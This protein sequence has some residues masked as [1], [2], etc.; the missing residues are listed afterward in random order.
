MLVRARDQSLYGYEDETM[1]WGAVSKGKL[2]IRNVPGSHRT[3]LKNPNARHS[4]KILKD[5]VHG[6]YFQI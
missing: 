5:L 3:M 6:N 2:D 1:G 4:A